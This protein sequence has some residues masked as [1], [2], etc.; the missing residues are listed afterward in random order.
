CSTSS[1][2]GGQVPTSRG[3]RV[4]VVDAVV[5]VLLVRLHDGV[6]AVRA[7]LAAGAALAV[8]AAVDA[9]VARLPEAEDSVAADRA[10]LAA[11]GAEP[12]QGQRVCRAG[13]L[14]L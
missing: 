14:A 9:V 1:S 4:T 8:A 13:R 12:I 11:G 5:A 10:A 2:P 6:A 7:Q 3:A